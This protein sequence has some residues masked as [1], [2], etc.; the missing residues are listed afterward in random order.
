MNI[1]NNKIKEK[2]LKKLI[3]LLEI[4]KLIKIKKIN[5]KIGKNITKLEKKIILKKLLIT[6]NNKFLF[7]YFKYTVWTRQE[8]NPYLLCAK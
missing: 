5:N 1:K 2:F 4:K 3:F 8:S 7:I 6:K